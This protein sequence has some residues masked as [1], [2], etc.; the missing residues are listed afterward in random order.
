MSSYIACLGS[1]KGLEVCHE[2]LFFPS[3]AVFQKKN[4]ERGKKD[5]LEVILS[6]FLMKCIFV[7]Q[8]IE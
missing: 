4:H 5:K 7:F 2:S 8:D 1:K 6:F 3:F